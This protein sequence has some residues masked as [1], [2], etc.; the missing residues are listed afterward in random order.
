MLFD[1]LLLDYQLKKNTNKRN[2]RLGVLQ[3]TLWINLFGF[4]SIDP[5]VNL[6]MQY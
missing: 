4:S 2:L 3:L 6:I 5:I 1:V